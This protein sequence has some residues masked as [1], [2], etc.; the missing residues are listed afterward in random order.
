MDSRLW[1]RL[2]LDLVE[3]VIASLPFPILFRGRAVCSNWATFI[4]SPK[5]QE[6]RASGLSWADLSPQVS[7]LLLFL[8]IGNNL[9]CTAYCPDLDRWLSMPALSCL[10]PQA[11]DVIASK[12]TS[13]SFFNACV[14]YINLLLV[15]DSLFRAN[16]IL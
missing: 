2:S 4:F 3:K 1:E 13:S 11:K 10:P 9:T 8:S 7:H 14:Y 12:S 15:D 6:I 16:Y 5:F